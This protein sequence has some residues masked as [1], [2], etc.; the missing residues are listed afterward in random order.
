MICTYLNYILILMLSDSI[1]HLSAAEKALEYG[2]PIYPICA[3]SVIWGNKYQNVHN[4]IV[5]HRS[6]KA[7]HPSL[8]HIV[9]AVND[10]PKKAIDTFLLEGMIVK[11]ISHVDYTAEYREFGFEKIMTKMKALELYECKWVVQMDL[12]TIVLGSIVEAVNECERGGDLLCGVPQT[13]DCYGREC[14]E[15]RANGNTLPFLVVNTGFLVY[16]TGVG[17]MKKLFDTL[18]ITQ[19]KREQSLWGYMIC[20]NEDVPLHMLS[21]KFNT[22]CDLS[23][24][25]DIHVLHYSVGP[26][27]LGGDVIPLNSELYEMHDGFKYYRKLS[28][29]VDGCSKHSLETECLSSDKLNTEKHDTTSLQLAYKTLDTGVRLNQCAWIEDRCISQSLS[30]LQLGDINEEMKQMANANAALQCAFKLNPAAAL[31][32]VNNCG[33]FCMKGLL[34]EDYCDKSFSFFRCTGLIFRHTID[35]R[36]YNLIPIGIASLSCLPAMYGFCILGG[37]VVVCFLF[38][39]VTSFLLIIVRNV[40]C[41]DCICICSK[42]YGKKDK[43][44]QANSSLIY[45]PI[46]LDKQDNL[47]L[48]TFTKIKDTIISINLTHTYDKTK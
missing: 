34:W 30:T 44:I 31:A 27:F 12:D 7:Q 41:S 33:T 46:V 38:C 32:F 29:G 23:T 11:R 26:A 17:L 10:V 18:A 43:V 21:W 24:T 8:P 19:A 47:Q 39:V 13:S 3:S 6:I 16:R 2:K 9:L 45:S 25:P 35:Y 5:K 42:W 28:L 20:Y 37:I 40:C 22:W 4:L 36:S 1:L 48:S 14:C 15:P